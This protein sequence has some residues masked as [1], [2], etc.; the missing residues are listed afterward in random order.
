MFSL[1]SVAFLCDFK[2]IRIFVMLNS[3]IYSIIYHS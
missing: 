2:L 1:K 3:I